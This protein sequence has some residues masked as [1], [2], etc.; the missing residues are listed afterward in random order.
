MRIKNGQI[1]YSPSDLINYSESPFISWLDRMFL[2]RAGGLKPGAADAGRELLQRKGDQH[3]LSFLKQLQE[4]GRDVCE[5]PI[6]YESDSIALTRNAIRDGREIIYQGVLTL[7]PFEGRSDFLVRCRLSPRPIYEVWDTKLARKSKPYFLLQLCCYAE[8]LAEEQGVIP[9]RV[10]VVLGDGSRHYFNTGDY[11]YYFANVKENFLTFQASFDELNPPPIEHVPP[12]SRWSSHIEE[13]LEQRDSLVQVANI[14]AATIK[15]LQAHGINTMDQLASTTSPAIAGIMES[16]F[17]SLKQQ[18]RLQVESKG[19]PSPR[20]EIVLPSSDEP[21]RGLSLLPPAS[22]GDVWFDMEGYP[23]FEGG[24]EYL[25]GAVVTEPDN[26]LRFFDWWACDRVTEKRAFEEFVDWVFA[27][28]K[29]DPSMHVFHYAAYEVSAL[30]RLMGRHGTREHEVDTLLRNEVFV[31]LYRIV[32]QSLRVGEPSYSIKYIE[33]LYKEKRAGDVATAMDSVV[34]YDKWLEQPDGETPQDSALLGAIRNYNRDDCE[35]IVQLTEFLRRVQQECEVSYVPPPLKKPKKDQQALTLTDFLAT[36]MLEA[37]QKNSDN[38]EARIVAL[39]AW[40]LHFHAREN[41]PGYWRMFDWHSMTEQ[42]LRH[43]SDCLAGL[44]RTSR[45]PEPDGQSIEYEYEF[46]PDQ[47]TSIVEGDK[48]IACHDL[49][50]RL[51]VSWLDLENGKARLR[52]SRT[53]DQPPAHLSLMPS[54]IVSGGQIVES[55]FDT[56]RRK[57]EQ[58]YMHPALADFLYRREPRIS[59]RVQGSPVVSRPELKDI[60]VAVRKMKNTTLFIQGPPGCG[61]TFTAASVIVQLI[62]EGK[63]IGVSSNSHKAIENLLSEVDRL[64]SVSGVKYSG[65]KIGSDSL[66]KDRRFTTASICWKKDGNAA[67]GGKREPFNLYGGTAY[68]FSTPGAVNAL[69][70]LFVDEAGQVAIA[71]LAGMAPSAANIVLIGDQMQ[72]DQ[73]LQGSHPGES[74]MSCL[75]YLLQGE[76]TVP[77]SKGIFLGKTWRMHPEICRFISE[78]IYSGKLECAP[79]TASRVLIRPNAL[80]YVTRDAG[81]LFVPVVHEGNTRCSPEEVAVIVD[82]TRELLQCRLV[83]DAGS[84]RPVTMNDILYVSPYNLQVR[85]IKESLPLANAASVDKFQGRQA[86]VVI[87]SMCTSN[88]AASP[89]GLDFVFSRNRLNVAI[90][91]AQ[92]LAIVVGNDELANSSCN[93]V[94]Q[95]ALVN[96]FC[97]ITKSHYRLAGSSSHLDLRG[98]CAVKC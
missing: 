76:T 65:V 59:G 35:S 10:A 89:R 15:R 8:M 47:D 50:V 43:D 27:R 69:D 58:G 42:E 61:K 7:A 97:R 49:Q 94:E 67:F 86:P 32:R 11:I 71:N 6:D 56:A 40:L 45:A 92:T 96:I 98:E 41:K 77:P 1:V 37:A 12:L 64:A 25:F 75:Q 80:R 84:S 26:Q 93:T 33:H 2:Q 66:R 31:D 34:F 85:L 28:W 95:M 3:E 87:L 46:D 5:L 57:H 17:D 44:R 4:E 54:E 53:K 63:R 91:R 18:A 16:T 88:G 38:E 82:I 22:T 55:L 29:A 19:L 83:S 68:A 78:T 70:Y 24:L 39:L 20:F 14:R 79:V 74:G 51:A 21:R 36:R 13:L 62:A 48:C 90:S 52:L 60:L 81:M 30:R 72:L 73:P 23:H 9:E